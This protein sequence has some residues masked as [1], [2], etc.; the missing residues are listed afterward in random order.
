MA[1]KL[2]LSLYKNGT[3]SILKWGELWHLIFDYSKLLL[4]LVTIPHHRWKTNFCGQIDMAEEYPLMI[5][6]LVQ[7]A[8]VAQ[9]PPVHDG[10]GHPKLG[11]QGH[12][13]ESHAWPTPHNSTCSYSA[14]SESF[15]CPVLSFL[16]LTMDKPSVISQLSFQ[17]LKQNELIPLPFLQYSVASKRGP[18]ML[19]CLKGAQWMASPFSLSHLNS[20][21]IKK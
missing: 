6:L 2:T 19:R 10:Q 3:T 1:Q 14:Q 16:H 18:W 21:P 5:S 9:I 11:S 15:R 12:Y 7:P 4:P 20:E 13:S 8:Q 17:A